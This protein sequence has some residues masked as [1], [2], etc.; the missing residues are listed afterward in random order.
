MKSVG[1]LGGDPGC[2]LSR[3]QL[4]ALQRQFY[5]SAGLLA[6]SQGT[7]PSQVTTNPVMAA[8]Y[9]RVL[10]GYLR[11]LVQ[12]GA[13]D[14]GQPIY[15]LDLG[16]GTGR[17]TY[18]VRKQL[19]GLMN[20]LGLPPLDV[21]F[22]LVDLGEANLS[23]QLQNAKLRPLLQT[24]AVSCA[25]FPPQDTDAPPELRL[26]PDGTRLL[27]DTISNPLIVLC[28]YFFDSIPHDAFRVRGGQLEECLVSLSGASADNTAST[29]EPVPL[30]RLQ[31]KLDY[32]PVAPDASY[33]SEPLWNQQLA[34]YRREL[35]DTHFLFPVAPLR[36][37]GWLGKLARGRLLL[38]AADKGY[39]HAEQI[40]GY[41][42]LAL[43]VHG[44]FSLPV[45]FHA[46]AAVA[47]PQGFTV[48]RGPRRESQL[49]IL[50]LVKGARAAWP[51][52]TLAF[53]D[54]VARNHP[55]DHHRVLRGAVMPAMEQP[56]G[57]LLSLLRQS[58][59]DPWFVLTYQDS[60]VH[61]AAQAPAALHPELIDDL[62]RVWDNDFPLGE[63][64]QVLAATL[65]RILRSAGCT[66]AAASY[67]QRP[68]ELA[69]PQPALPD[70]RDNGTLPADAVPRHP[71]G[72][73][74]PF[75]PGPAP[76]T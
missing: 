68:I 71:P 41:Q 8:A 10:L 65:A 59:Y 40:R 72:G 9:A 35:P 15:V 5:A 64:H 54:H 67:A 45:N 34:R 14:V 32:R 69:A 76:S 31:L 16:A 22:V 58:E 19:A 73:F 24:G 25:A 57:Y 6:W 46:L 21:R 47:G 60:L 30:S 17:L 33:Y 70:L 28:N 13:V 26:L 75:G 11:D 7:V 62:A 50:G 23:A 52:T 74:G 18:L 29:K 37:L 53:A 48:L 36:W 20:G 27:P 43:A 39:D 44:S 4:Y 61:E 55:S 63:R 2:A 49:K 38:L 56:L 3:S 1:G 42:N 51:E 12:A 66:L